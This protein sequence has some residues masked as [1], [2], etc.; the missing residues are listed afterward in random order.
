MKKVLKVVLLA[1]AVVLF[2]AQF[3]RPDLTNPPIDPAHELRA[4]A[5]VQSILDRSCN[6]CHSNRTRYPWYAQISPLSWWL[7]DHITEGRREVNFSEFATYSARRKGRKFKE[8]CEQVKEGEM[9]LES[10]LPLHPSAKLSDA[11]RQVLCQW[12]SAESA[13]LTSAASRHRGSS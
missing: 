7:K 13:A 4:P 3:V 8:I 1:L 6:D 11:D 2:A 9:P 12:T 10:Y 5:N